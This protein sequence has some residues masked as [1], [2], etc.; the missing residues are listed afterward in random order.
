MRGDKIG[1]PTSPPVFHAI[2]RLASIAT[3][4]TEATSLK[5]EVA[6]AVL[7]LMAIEAT[8]VLALMASL[9]TEAIWLTALLLSEV[10]PL[11]A[12]GERVRSSGV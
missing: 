12:C 3:L 6:T 7:A 8:A 9:A 4:V 11:I 10:S 1:L 2:S 5:N